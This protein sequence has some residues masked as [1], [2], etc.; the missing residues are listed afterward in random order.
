MRKDITGQRFGKLVAV[1]RLPTRL[2]PSGRKY[3]V[4][5]CQCD[6]GKQ[7]EA[8]LN[9][10]TEGTKRS[11]GCLIKE[12]HA[13]QCRELGKQSTKH[14]DFGTKLYG[15]WAAMKRRC[16][17][18]HA[19]YFELYGGRGIKVCQDWH[20]YEPFKEWALTNGYQQGLSID[21]IDCDGNYEPGNC[22][23]VTM[24]AQQ[25]N[26][27]NNRHYNYKG[28]SYTVKEIAEMVGLKPRTVQGRIERG[29][30]I[31]EVVETPCLKSN[32]KYFRD[33]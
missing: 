17:N 8:R 2:S 28:K 9:N 32:G 4:W 23:W 30:T 27:R 11:C 5:L 25:R 18:P 20:E 16:Y 15:V 22:R 12:A 24:A 19:K 1:K 26:C 31:E 33:K 21:R 29:W 7:V 6:C 13:E 3:S 14:G 10:L